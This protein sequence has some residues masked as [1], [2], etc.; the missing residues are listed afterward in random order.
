MPAEEQK[1]SSGS[2]MNES[3]CNSS[4][5]FQANSSSTLLHSTQKLPCDLL[6][7]SASC[8]NNTEIE[9]K[10]CKASLEWHERLI[11]SDIASSAGSCSSNCKCSYFTQKRLIN[12]KLLRIPGVL[13]VLRQSWWSFWPPCRS[14]LVL[15]SA[16]ASFGEEVMTVFLSQTQSDCSCTPASGDASADATYLTA[17]CYVWCNSRNSP[18]W[19]NALYISIVWQ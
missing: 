13:Q 16:A 4:L 14:V 11:Y 18:D 7:H 1:S 8:K 12:A 5:C 3:W 10:N 6:A 19:V 17:T 15:S 2:R 9:I